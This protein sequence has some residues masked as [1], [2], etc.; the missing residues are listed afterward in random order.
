[1]SRC[2][3]FWEKNDLP[4]KGAPPPFFSREELLN[5]QTIIQEDYQKGNE[6][7]TRNSQTIKPI[8]EKTNYWAE[9]VKPEGFVVEFDNRWQISGNYKKYTWCK[10][11]KEGD[12][13]KLIF[14]T[15]G[16]SGDTE[17]LVFK[18]D[19][20]WSSRIASNQ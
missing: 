15:V 4:T 12:K 9:K 7:S 6:E 18:L 17:E 16:T 19:C 11:Y 3:A 13:D 2:Y 1:M 14:F 8:Y 20:K 5:F 10:I